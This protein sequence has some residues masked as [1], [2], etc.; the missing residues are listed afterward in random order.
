MLLI[1]EFKKCIFFNETKRHSNIIVQEVDH[2][3]ILNH[4]LMEQFSFSFQFFKNV[5]CAYNGI[6]SDEVCKNEYCQ[7]C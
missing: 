5:G 7:Q 3:A 1:S 6:I 4:P 2:G